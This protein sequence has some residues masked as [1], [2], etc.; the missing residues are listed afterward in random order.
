MSTNQ[1]KKKQ[2]R[3]FMNLALQQANKVL[4]NTSENPAV[5][6]VIVKN[7]NLISAGHTGF[8]G[9]PH[10]ESNAIVSFG[11]IWVV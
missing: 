3:Y 4:G 9:I 2:D 1:N 10:A 5:G 8:N 6:C 7:G 11:S